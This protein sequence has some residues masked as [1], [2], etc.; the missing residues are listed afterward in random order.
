[1]KGMLAALCCL[2]LASSHL[3]LAQDKGTAQKAPPT[4][5]ELDAK[6]KAMTTQ[7]GLCANKAGRDKLKEGSREHHQFMTRCLSEKK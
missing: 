4:K 2:M 1:M 5:K 6:K 7:A 3:V